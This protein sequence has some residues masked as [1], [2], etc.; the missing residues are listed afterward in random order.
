[1]T[2]AN[3]QNAMSEFGQVDILLEMVITC[4]I[5]NPQDV[6]DKSWFEKLEHALYLLESVYKSKKAI[7][8]EAL[9][10]GERCE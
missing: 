3:V 4:L 8:I 2:S 10:G 1:M 9:K 5:K 6:K 7:L